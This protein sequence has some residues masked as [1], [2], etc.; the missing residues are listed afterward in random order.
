MFANNEIGTIEP[1]KEICLDFVDSLWTNRGGFYGNWTEDDAY[2]VL[3]GTPYSQKNVMILN[4]GCTVDEEGERCASGVNP[5]PYWK[6]TDYGWNYNIDA[7]QVQ[8][9]VY[10]QQ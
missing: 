6:G 7:I 5:Y 1:V 10:G 8:H 9:T 4:H 2:A 3:Q